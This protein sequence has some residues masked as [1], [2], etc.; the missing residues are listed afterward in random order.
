[1]LAALGA[2]WERWPAMWSSN[3]MALVTT[4]PISIADVITLAVFI[5]HRMN[6]K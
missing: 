1:L 5:Y 6:R 2:L 3:A 4:I